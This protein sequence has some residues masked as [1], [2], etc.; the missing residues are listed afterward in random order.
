M[1]QKLH[2]TYGFS[3]D[4][5]KVLLGGWNTW[6]QEH[7]KDP[8]GYPTVPEN[9]DAPAPTTGSSDTNPIQVVPNATVQLQPAPANTVAPN[10]NAAPPPNLVPQPTP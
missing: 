10:G 7:A 2:D 1:A 4:N 5:L 8:K 3:Y 6:K 9:L